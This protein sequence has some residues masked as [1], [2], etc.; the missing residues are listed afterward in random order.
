MQVQSRS[1]IFF[2]RALHSLFY[3]H[4]F[5]ELNSS[6]GILSGEMFHFYCFGIANR[7]DPDQASRYVASEQGLH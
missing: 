2:N 3:C 5:N 1:L 4:F 7:L 6:I